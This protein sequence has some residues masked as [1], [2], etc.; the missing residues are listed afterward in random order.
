MT[1]L[2]DGNPW[3]WVIIDDNPGNEQYVGQE[4]EQT[5]VAF[6]P[7]FL[8]KEEALKGYNLIKRE[9]T[10]KYEVQAVRFKELSKDCLDHQFVIF[11]LDGE[12]TVLEK[13]APAQ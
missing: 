11:L 12:G 13:I 7:A 5:G 6:I 10:R 4:D 8:T 3:M 9:R 2:I 1:S